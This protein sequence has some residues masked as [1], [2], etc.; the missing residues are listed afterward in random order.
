VC[1][2]SSKVSCASLEALPASLQ[3]LSPHPEAIVV[4]LSVN[5]NEF[6]CK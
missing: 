2:E 1:L 5:V 6:E 3:F 4:L